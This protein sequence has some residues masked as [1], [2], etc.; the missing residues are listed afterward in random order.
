LFPFFPFF[1][2]APIPPPPP[3][4]AIWRVEG[5]GGV[6]DV[7]VLVKV[8]GR[9]EC[10]VLIGANANVDFTTHATVTIE[11]LIVSDR[12]SY[13]ITKRMVQSY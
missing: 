10:W 7:P 13:K 1:L 2:E 12:E 11:N 5:V 6:T 3:N 4:P 9:H 8:L